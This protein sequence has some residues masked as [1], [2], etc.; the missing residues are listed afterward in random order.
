[1]SDELWRAS[2]TEL[3]ALIADG[4]CSSREVVQAHLDR[5]DEAND[6]VRAIVARFDADALAEA[7]KADA[8]RVAGQPLGPLHG[9]PFTVKENI[10]VGGRPTTQGV[11]ALAHATAGSDE[12][13]VDRLRVGGAIP[14]ARTNLPDMGV[15]LHTDSAL[16]GPT[17][18]PWDRD[19][20][21]GGSSGGEAAALATGM[22][23]LGLGNDMCGSLRW[24]A[25]CCGVST[26]KP[27]LGLL[28]SRPQ[29]GAALSVE[30]LAVPG[31]LA[32]TVADLRVAYHLMAGP[33][34]GDPWSVPPMD[35]GRLHEIVA[36]RRVTVAVDPGGGG[37]DPDVRAG[38][39]RAAEI[40]DR[41]GWQV[42]EGEP[43]RFAEAARLWPEFVFGTPE[44]DTLGPLLSP[45]ALRVLGLWAGA[46]GVT[47]DP[48]I[49]A[50]ALRRRS[51]ILAEWAAHFHRGG[52]WLT[53]TGTEQPFE[54][55]ADLSDVDRMGR[56]LNGHRVIMATNALGLPSTVVPVGSANGLPQ[57]VQLVGPRFAEAACLDAAE[58]IEREVET[59]TP[60]NP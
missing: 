9:V 27:T 1:M 12:P 22:T 39:E 56:I 60:I 55:G 58:M 10:D 31:P 16:H 5:M 59:M 17:L 37:S 51:K 18:N 2:A 23:P 35:P 28:P 43:P 24:P 44:E 57:S 30:L 7:D 19:R 3:A 4:R 13:V 32:R 34:P 52:L 46:S 48:A 14:I 36:A 20:T 50:D 47:A 15:R 26:L 21:P 29:P 38:I 40:L 8:Q 25:Q 49:L 41:A 45:D 6:R 53:A 33:H 42:V 54:V 11:P